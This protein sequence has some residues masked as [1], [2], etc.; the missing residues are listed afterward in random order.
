LSDVQIVVPRLDWLDAS[1]L[2]LIADLL[3]F[4]ELA[5]SRLRVLA[6]LHANAPEPK[7]A[8]LL[9]LAQCA[10]EEFDAHK[11]RALSVH[12][13]SLLAALRAAPMPL[14]HEKLM[15]VS[16]LRA[17]EFNSSLRKLA[18]AGYAAAGPRVGLGAA[19]EL[20]PPTDLTRWREALLEICDLPDARLSVNA[21]LG[22]VG[23]EAAQLARR[24]L[25][26]GEHALALSRFALAP[27][28]SREPLQHALALAG[29][30][31][32]QAALAILNA[33]QGAPLD[34][35][36]VAAELCQRGALSREQAERELRAAERHQ[37]GSAGEVEAITLRAALLRAA[38]KH[39][40]ALKLLRRVPASQ[41][42][43]APPKTRAAYL[44]E[45]ALA[46]RRAG[47]D[48]KCGVL[49][50]EAQK[51]NLSHA[52][53]LAV[54]LR[55]YE[56]GLCTPARLAEAA[57]RALD[58]EAARVALRK[59]PAAIKALRHALGE[60]AEKAPPQIPQ[61]ALALCMRH[62]ASLAATLIEGELHVLPAHAQSRAGLC[63]WLEAQLERA[64]KTPGV[65]VPLNVPAGEFKGDTLL[66]LPALG[67]QGPVV[68]LFAKPAN[69]APLL[70]YVNARDVVRQW[71][72][73]G[74]LS[75]EDLQSLLQANTGEN[76]PWPTSP[77]NSHPSN[78]PLT[79]R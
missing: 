11:I 43:M 42:G 21:A 57:A 8:R 7:V 40:A 22:L 5:G 58:V 66:L 48:D 31:H 64:A 18:A 13:K 45:L 39:S 61:D 19:S 4:A 56:C 35:A 24:A 55:A 26:D 74:A 2:D 30:G 32:T 1:S 65:L 46:W 75:A 6:G 33:E 53:A 63:A 41:A 77:P 16:G 70:E 79:S 27:R 44:V 62:G 38:G 15:H 29:C 54:E 49:F 47:R 78:E 69:A 51:L 52:T 37:R 59:S 3:E 72:N 23:A 76:T 20:L 71:L 34:R 9:A 12:D 25:A 68:A 17:R 10:D 28:Q 60:P 14:E 73:A 36:R 67:E 50:S